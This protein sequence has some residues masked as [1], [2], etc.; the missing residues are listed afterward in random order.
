MSAKEIAAKLREYQETKALLNEVQDALSALE[1]EIKAMM[2]EN[3]EIS[4]DG[5]KAKWTRYTTS[6]FDSKTFK[7]EHGAMYEQYVK[8]VPAQRFQVVA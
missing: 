6:R 8:T 4:A 3:E 2:G 5:I 7:A 1:A